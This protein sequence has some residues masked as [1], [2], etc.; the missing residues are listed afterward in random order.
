M[1]MIDEYGK[2]RY[3][4]V[5]VDELPKSCMSC[6]F[7]RVDNRLWNGETYIAVQWCALHSGK[8]YDD[9]WLESRW[10][11]KRD[12]KCPLKTID[13]LVLI[14]SYEYCVPPD[15][16]VEYNLPTPDYYGV[17]DEQP[18]DVDVSFYEVDCY[19]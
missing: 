10:R 9:I 7:L 13:E 5:Y 17:T 12:E 3:N 2:Q 1:I 14:K 4:C 8:N 19:D 18:T 11:D 15:T 16:D 6:P